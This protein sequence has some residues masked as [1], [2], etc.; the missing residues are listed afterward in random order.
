MSLSFS[1]HLHLHLRLRL[2]HYNH[3]FTSLSPLL[4]H[5][6]IPDSLLFRFTSVFILF[7]QS[8]FLSFSSLSFLSPFLPSSSSVMC[9]SNVQVMLIG[10]IMG[11]KGIQLTG[12]IHFSLCL[13]FEFHPPSYSSKDSS[14][15]PKSP[16]LKTPAAIGTVPPLYTCPSFMH[17][18]RMLSAQS[19]ISILEKVPR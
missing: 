13:A 7:S 19:A 15:C 12:R 11:P 10:S 9:S 16:T 17:T 18:R 8:L 4:S 6:S 5:L 3:P 1:S 2:L 14:L